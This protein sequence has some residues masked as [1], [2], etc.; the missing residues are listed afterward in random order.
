MS[1]TIHERAI[2]SEARE[3]CL[4]LARVCESLHSWE[5]GN[6]LRRAAEYLYHE[7]FRALYRAE[8]AAIG[9]R[10]GGAK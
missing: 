2:H 5:G 3:L 10:T 4:A 9:V 8:A 1:L 7:K 6:K